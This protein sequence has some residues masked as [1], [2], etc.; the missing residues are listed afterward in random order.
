M[1]EK[2]IIRSAQVEDGPL[3]RAFMK[4]L[5]RY[6]K[7]E[8][9][10]TATADQLAH[11]VASGQA[12]AFFAERE[13]EVVGFLFAYTVCSAF[14]GASGYYIDAL[15]IDEGFR[16][17]G[18]GRAL[19]VQMAKECVAAGFG[20]L[21]WGCLDWNQPAL[22]FYQKIGAQVVSEMRIYRI[23]TENIRQLAAEN[24]L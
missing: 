9:H 22:D 3:M 8:D 1:Q 19:M 17:Q 15:Y 5:G 21:E 13:G 6:Q 18:I 4:K 14:I 2:I 7:M 12:R 20:R 24:I 10:I 23:H 16:S 11:L